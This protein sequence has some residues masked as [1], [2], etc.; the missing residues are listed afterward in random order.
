ML[1]QVWNDSIDPTGY[2]ISEKYDGIRA[3]WSGEILVSRYGRTLPAPAWFLE[4]LPK[5]FPIDGELWAGYEK[6]GSLIKILKSS[7]D[8]YWGDCTLMAFDSPSETKNFE[9]R[10]EILHKN[11]TENDCLKFVPFVMCKGHDHL[12]QVLKEVQDRNGEGLML[13]KAEA[14]YD[15]GRSYNMLKVKT[16][17]DAEV[18]MVRKAKKCVGFDC[19]LPNNVEIT[20]RCT[21][22]DFKHPPPAGTVLKV[23]HF[24]EWKN[25]GKLKNAYFWR[26]R[27]DGTTWD[28]IVRDYVDRGK[29]LEELE[30]AEKE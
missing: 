14:N 25:S 12:K 22:T 18:M 16:Q 21:Y 19:I 28:D 1:S 26:I 17:Q 6:F 10:I 30:S 8:D 27:N 20:I 4:K 15:V 11:A 24:G 3:F 5:G 2:W 7:N 13:R 23:K 29:V 9:E